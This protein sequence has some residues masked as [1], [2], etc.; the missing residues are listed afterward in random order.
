MEN[1]IV[2][3]ED[4]LDR[5]KFSLY[6]AML[7]MICFAVLMAD[8]IDT[9][10]MGYIAPSLLAE[11]GLSKTQLGP[12]LSAALIGIGIGSLV[13]GP[14]ADNFGRKRVIVAAVLLFGTG[15]LASAA[16]PTLDVLV[17]LRLVTGIGLGAAIP[18]VVTLMSEYSPARRRSLVVMVMFCGF[19]F[20]NALAGIIASAL[21]PAHGWRSLLLLGGVIPMVILL[22][23]VPLLPESVRFLVQRSAD[24]ASIARILG[25]I[26]PLPGGS[27]SFRMATSVESSRSSISLIVRRDRRLGTLLLWIGYFMGLFI[28]Y[29]LT[30]WMPTFLKE[31]GVSGKTAALATSMFMIG[32][33][34]GN[35]LYGWMMDRMRPHMVVGAGF[36]AASVFLYVVGNHPENVALL[37]GLLFASGC[38]MSAI[39]A[40]M[41]LAAQFYD[42]RCRATGVSWMLGIGRSGGILGAWMGGT[43]MGWGWGFGRIFST[44]A[45]LGIIAA[46]CIVVKGVVY[47][48]PPGSRAIEGARVSVLDNH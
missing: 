10:A 32:S 39:V 34:F 2:D 46:I 37:R 43:M 14:L 1:A 13:S 11:W 7:L 40:M 27:I 22:F 12:V 33:V 41:P 45:A 44:L 36:V 9:A 21:I 42:T 6:Q 8:G 28:T 3:V 24:S 29:L 31:S 30:T 48:H 35:P 18:N 25:R 16:A 23:I 38:A 15:S 47:R 4:F 19:S 20:G 5:H 17:S 26:E